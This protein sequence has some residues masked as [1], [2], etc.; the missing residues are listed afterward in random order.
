MPKWCVPAGAVQRSHRSYRTNWSYKHT[1]RAKI[2]RDAGDTATAQNTGTLE[3]TSTQVPVVC[4]C[5]SRHKW[6]VPAGAVCPRWGQCIGRIGHTGPIALKNT[7]AGPKSP[8][9]PG[10]QQQ[11]KTPEHL[12][13]Q[14]PKCQRC[15]PATPGTSGV[16]PLGH[17]LGQCIGRIGHIGQIG[18]INTPAG[19]NSELRMT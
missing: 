2:T 7:P 17:P 12:N 18:L 13:T 5:D 1:S 10:T 3:H 4:P 15:V 14:A 11:H 19:L 9:M 6:C 16:S 8:G